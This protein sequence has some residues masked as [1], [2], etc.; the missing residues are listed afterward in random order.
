MRYGTTA[1]STGTTTTG[2]VAGAVQMLTYDG[3][4]WIRDYWNNTTYS[5]AGLGQGYVTCSTAAATVAK[6]ASLSSYSLTT[7]GIVSVKFTN[8]VPASATLNIASKGAKAIYH[9]GA[10]IKADVIKAGDVATFIYSSQYHL[11]SVDRWQND[12]DGI[13]TDINNIQTE[14]DT[15]VDKDGNKVLSTN[16]YTTAEKEKLS[17]IDSGATR[18]VVDSALSSTSTNPVQNK[19]IDAAIK[20]HGTHVTWSTTS[21][22]ANGTAT[23]GSEAK[24]ARGDHVHP[25][26]TTRAAASDL[27]ALKSLVGNTSVSSQITDALSNYYTKAQIDSYEL[28]SIADIDEIC[29]GSGVFPGQ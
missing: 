17:S 18:T 16:D 23:V 22:K 20:S 25:T 11:I 13:H 19:V 15:K 27:T 1:A 12:I 29:S 9:K 6:T 2:W 14:L 28:I 8:D 3:T 26:D 5:N 10:A 24:V 7:G 4:N 21:P